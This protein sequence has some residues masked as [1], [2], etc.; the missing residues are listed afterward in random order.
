MDV[1]MITFGL[2]GITSAE[3]YRGCDEEAP[4]FVEVPGLSAKVWLS[5]PSSGTYGGIYTFRDKSSLDD[6]LASD[7]FRSIVDDESTV[8]V[9]VQ[10]YEVLEGP[11]RVTRGWDVQPA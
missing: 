5:D 11:T 4:L 8:E 6:Y 1:L 9:K 7:L 10:V 3:Y 2:H